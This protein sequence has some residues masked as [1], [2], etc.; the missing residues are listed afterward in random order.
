MGAA[1]AAA[2]AVVVVADGAGLPAPEKFATPG[3]VTIEAL[4][5]KPYTAIQPKDSYASSTPATDGER[6]YSYFGA[7]GLYCHDI[8][9]KLVWKKDLGKFKTQHGWASSSPVLDGGRLFLLCDNETKSFLLAVDGKTGDELWRA[10]RDEKSSWGSP[11]VWK[12]MTSGAR[13][14]VPKRSSV[15]WLAS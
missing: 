6:V 7:S 10:D 8:G 14:P 1:G 5:Q 11:F 2:A 9:G 4:E 12:T 13:S 15:R 3:V